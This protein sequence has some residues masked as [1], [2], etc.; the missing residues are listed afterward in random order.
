[1]NDVDRWIRDEGPPPPAVHELLAAM[2]VPPQRT[3][4]EIAASKRSILAALAEQDRRFAQEDRER[5]ERHARF[6]RWILGAVALAAAAALFVASF[7]YG[8]GLAARLGTPAVSPS[9]VPGVFDFGH[10]LSPPS[11]LPQ[12][13]TTTF[14]GS[15]RH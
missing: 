5:S 8:P 4:E 7:L 6:R 1:M 14:T 11:G 9:P 10:T 13:V 12:R 3:P 15:G 2:I